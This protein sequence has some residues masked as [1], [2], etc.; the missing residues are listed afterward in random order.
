MRI[1]GPRNTN[2]VNGSKGPVKKSGGAPF[3]LPSE[4]ASS[5]NTSVRASGSIGSLDA[6]LALQ[7]VEDATAGRKKAMRRGFRMLDLLDEI[8]LGLLAGRLPKS[9]LERLVAV[10]TDAVPDSDDPKLSHVL[11]EIELRA[12]VELAKFGHPAA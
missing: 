8:K 11:S 3:S 9:H 7:E 4:G 2:G 12:R 1:T 6:I 5:S 10:V